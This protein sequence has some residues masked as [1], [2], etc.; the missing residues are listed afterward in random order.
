MATRMRMSEGSD[1][2]GRHVDL[3]VLT[4]VLTPVA[5]IGQ[6][7]DNRVRTQPD[8]GQW[9]WMETE[10]QPRPMCG[11]DS[12]SPLEHLQLGSLDIDLD[13]GWDEV[14]RGH[15]VVQ[16]CHVDPGLLQPV[17]LDQ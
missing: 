11:Q 2:R 4:D 13:D 8:F 3:L 12:F 16:R 10:E 14:E 15:L 1:W 9:A 6:P 17:G 5:A 7:F